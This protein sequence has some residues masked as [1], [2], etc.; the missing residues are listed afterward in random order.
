MAARD[1]LMTMYGIQD[2]K[3]P[4]DF[5]QTHKEQ[6]ELESRDSTKIASSTPL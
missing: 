1:A 4:F 5:E 2:Y 6:Y 3:L